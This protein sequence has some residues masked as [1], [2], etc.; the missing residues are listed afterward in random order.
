VLILI[1][2]SNH[3]WLQQVTWLYVLSVRGW[4]AVRGTV[5]PGVDKVSELFDVLL[6][7][8]TV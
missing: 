3:I 6:D 2:T 7:L 8:G 5:G 1:A 4:F